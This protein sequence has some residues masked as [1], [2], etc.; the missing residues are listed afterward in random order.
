MWKE[1]LPNNCPPN[2]A[3]EADT[4]AFRV[5][6]NEEPSE[7]DFIPYVKMYPE[8]ERYKTFCKAHA[9]SFYDTIEHAV[10]AIREARERSRNIGRLVAKVELKSE[11]G[12]L[13]Y[14]ESNGHYSFWLKEN[15]S[16]T[17]FLTQ[18]IQEANV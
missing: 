1:Q 14:N 10:S 2:N 11:H 4:I 5:L 3:Y 9:L 7:N 13:E 17:D 18:E 15:Y 6:Q 8:N 16:Y 12:K